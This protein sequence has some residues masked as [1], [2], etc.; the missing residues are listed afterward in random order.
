MSIP[1]RGRYRMIANNTSKESDNKI[2]DD[3]VAKKFGFS[4]GLVPG[5][6]VYAYMTQAPVNWWG[7]DW[8]IRGSASCRFTKPVYDGAKTEVL[9]KPTKGDNTLLDLNVESGGEICASGW[10]ALDAQLPDPPAPGEIPKTPLPDE[11]PPAAPESLRKDQVLG[12]YE[13]VFEADG[14]LTYLDDV[15]E[16]NTLYWHDDIV[17]PSFLLRLANWSLSANVVLGPWIHVGSEVQ[18]FSLVRYGETIAAHAVVL[19]NYERKGHLFVDVK[20][21]LLVDGVR[22]A[23]QFKH[24]AIYRPRQLA[25]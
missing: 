19:D 6:D 10:A 18:N 20:V 22:P 17:H 2:H 11:R 21:N 8:L 14:A 4:G 15:R 7:L 5:V 23:A 9:A 1:E 3:E 13:T 16:R 24:T 12:T 25:G